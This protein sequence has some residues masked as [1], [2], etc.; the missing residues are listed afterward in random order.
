M[1][2]QTHLTPGTAPTGTEDDFLWQHL[3]ALP[4]FRALLRA[5]EARFYQPLLPLEE[6]VLDVGCGDGHFA[7]VAFPRPLLAGIDPA[8][9]SLREAQEWGGYRGL[10]QGLGDA[11]PFPNGH[12]STVVSNSVLEHI[13]ALEPVLA[14]VS[15]VLRCPDPASGQPGGRFIFCVP[16]H[17][18][19]ELLFFADL[20]RGLKL[21][22]AA[23]AYERYF[24]RISRHHHCDGAEVWQQRLAAAGLEVTTSFY[25][26]SRQAT[27]ALDLG[28]Y[29]GAPSLIAKK[30]FGRW[31]VVPTRKNLALTERWLRPL[32]EEPLPDV[33]AYLFVVA[34]KAWPTRRI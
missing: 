16:G 13:P 11:L 31:I 30:L 6:P 21:A 24:N 12:F 18:F 25:Y 23:G 2:D 19:T 29:L 5:V 22:G 27:H 3:K 32:Y 7:S 8:I 9:A 20:F 14:E 1:S 17:H 34:Q 15:R 26:F 33:G 4:A 10:A 28:H